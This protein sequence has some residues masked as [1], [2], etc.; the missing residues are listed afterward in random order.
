MTI[1]RGSSHFAQGPAVDVAPPGLKPGDKRPPPPR[2]T[3]NGADNQ[4][5]SRRSTKATLRSGLS[6]LLFLRVV[7]TG[8]KETHA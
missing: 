6:N 8:S 3:V 7:R 1:R 2:N 5:L 4:R